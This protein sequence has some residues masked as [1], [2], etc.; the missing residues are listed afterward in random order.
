[1]AA[2][3]L[4]ACGSTGAAQ[5]D[6]G[7]GSAGTS[8]SGGNVGSGG[9]GGNG[10]SASTTG[11][12]GVAGFGIAGRGGGSGGSPGTGGS[13]GGSAG[14][15]GAGGRP[16][17]VAQDL[18]ATPVVMNVHSDDPT[19]TPMG[20][21]ISS[22]WY[23]HTAL[24][25]YGGTPTGVACSSQFLGVLEVTALSI[26]EG[27]IRETWAI[28]FGTT[29]VV[30]YPDTWTYQTNGNMLT[31]TSTCGFE[32]AHSEMYTATANQLFLFRSNDTT[33][34]NDVT[35]VLTYTKQ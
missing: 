25:Y 31:G 29:P 20:G 22:G 3:G 10:G 16:A 30:T 24:T 15:G 8:A 23:R 11:T 9:N 27:T 6:G 19:P 33:C 12:G 32:D 26:T 18:S 35:I 13:T 14:R 7:A 2:F 34:W 17:C 28:A 1:M 5:N 4:T 21:A